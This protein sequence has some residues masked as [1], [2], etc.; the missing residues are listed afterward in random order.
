[1]VVIKIKQR[2][3][4]IVGAIGALVSLA[5]YI[6]TPS[7]PTPDKI[8]VFLVFVFMIF[9]QATE[10]LKRLLPFVA[11]IIV[12]ESFRSIVPKLNSHVNYT[13][14]P[15]IDRMLFGNLPTVYLQ[16]WLWHGHVQWYD[17]V[18]YTPYLLFFAL[19]IGLAL[20]VWKT[21]DKHYWEVVTAYLTLF[22]AAFL[23]FLAFPTAPPWLAS[24]N[25]YIV[26]IVRT[27]SY[28]WASL[29]IHNFASV[30]NHL[31]ANPVAAVPSLHSA[32]ATLLAIFVF[33][34]YG[35]RWG[36]VSLIYPVLIYVGVV[37]E[38]EHYVFDVLMGIVYAVGAYYGGPYVLRYIERLGGKIKSLKSAPVVPK[39]LKN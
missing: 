29:G 4:Q 39:S 37:Y 19:P 16:R 20:L 24:Q 27:S 3:L 22:F 17:F 18:L 15:H 36:L 35:K 31:A 5:A 28:V 30:Y 14:A 9:E 2:L 33:K 12:Y 34:L 21:R 6:H 11:L 10:M 26:P 8:L 13:L 23:T 38:G 25:H 32:C 1:M 7:F